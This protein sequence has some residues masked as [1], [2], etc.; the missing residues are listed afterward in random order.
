MQSQFNLVLFSMFYEPL[1]FSTTHGHSNKPGCYCIYPNV[2]IKV[3]HICDYNV[4]EINHCVYLHMEQRQISPA[5]THTGLTMN[6][7]Q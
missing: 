7:M 6:N 2:Y 3:Q 1:L 5:E 4:S